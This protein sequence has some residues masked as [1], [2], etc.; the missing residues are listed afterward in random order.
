MLLN[1]TCFHFFFLKS[2]SETLLDLLGG[3]PAAEPTPAPVQPPAPA[4]S[5]GGELLDLLGDLDLGS[6]NAGLHL[7]DLTIVFLIFSDFTR[8]VVLINYFVAVNIS[9]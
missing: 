1:I 3:G 7:C 8:R 6:T 9:S 4:A 2:Q 5:S